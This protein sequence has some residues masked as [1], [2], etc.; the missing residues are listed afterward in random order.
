MDV[1]WSAYGRD[2]ERAVSVLLYGASITPAQV[3]AGAE[4]LTD[5]S[6]YVERARL[7]HNELS[8]TC[9]FYEE[10]YCAG[11]PKPGQLLAVKLSARLYWQGV[12]E[13]V[14]DYR[15]E[16]GTRT[17][18]FVARS[19]D[20]TPAWRE[21]QRITREY[22]QGTRLD[23]IARDVAVIL[24]L[25]PQEIL[26]S[27]VGVSTPQSTTQLAEVPAWAMLEQVLIPAGLYPFVD[28]L[29]RLRGYSRDITRAPDQVLTRDRVVRVSGSRSRPAISR[30]VLAWRDPNL[31][32][33]KQQD[34]VLA[35]ATIT[36][37][38]FQA[39]QKQEVYWS[40]DRTLRALDTRL[41]IRQSA[42]SG[43]IPICDETYQQFRDE[44][45]DEVVG[46]LIRLDTYAYVAPLL[47]YM[48][49]LKALSLVPDGVD[50]ANAVTISVGRA[51]E[52][53]A[54]VGILLTM[55][56]IGTGIYEIW[57][58]P[59]DYANAVNRTAAFNFNAPETAAKEEELESDFISGETHAQAVVGREFLWRALSANSYGATV[60]DDPRIEIGD[61]VEFPDGDRMV[62]TGYGRDL[63]PGAP[64]VMDLTGFPV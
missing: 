27:A 15:E 37:G 36:A 57:G 21:V 29:G 55:A 20:A 10:L 31:T 40:E 14:T 60:V 3:V 32:M 51:S 45:N 56:S 33:V 48:I 2:S 16:V 34:R 30:L 23:L 12:V 18:S 9:R 59:F 19:R 41:V 43:L 1:T 7:A 4:P 26:I 62:V 6:P 13:A 11:Q 52:T 47:A 61:L 24:G 28:G 44:G 22:P 39:V 50:I 46:G 17:M 54:E 63:S 58:T 64:A 5:M 53:A 38:F 42:N 25:E 8:I 35:S 49:G